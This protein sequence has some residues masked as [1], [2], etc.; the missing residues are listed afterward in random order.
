MKFEIGKTYYGINPGKKANWREIT[1][2]AIEN[3]MAAVRIVNPSNDVSLKVWN[4][5]SHCIFS[6]WG[7]G[8][9]QETP[10]HPEFKAGDRIV[11]DF[12]N[13]VV[14]H[15]ILR[16]KWTNQRPD[17]ECYRTQWVALR[18]HKNGTTRLTVLDGAYVENA[19]PYK[20]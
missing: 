7:E 4:V 2:L 19:T 14:S 15:Y 12:Q 11:I 9:Y 13:E 16:E 20:K 1:I 18:I 8:L 6:G 5:D 17:I 10:W 3:G